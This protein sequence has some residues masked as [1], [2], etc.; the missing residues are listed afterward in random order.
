MRTLDINDIHGTFRFEYNRELFDALCSVPLCSY[1]RVDKS[2]RV[3]I[4][5]QNFPS[6]IKVVEK[7]DFS[8]TGDLSVVEKELSD[9]LK[10]R[11][12][13]QQEVVD[14][15]DYHKNLF[16]EW[17][18]GFGKTLASIK[19]IN[20]HKGRWLFVYKETTHLKNHLEDIEKHGMSHLL[21]F[22]DW[23]TYN[24][25]HKYSDNKYTGLILDEC[26][27]STSDLRQ[28]KLS[29]FKDCKIIATSATIDGTVKN[30]L[31]DIFGYFHTHKVTFDDAV[32][33]GILPKPR[34]YLVPLVLDNKRCLR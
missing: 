25:I 24:S 10:T 14:L 31:S 17:V 22:I 33:W 34:I 16:I 20:E 26:H 21:P 8:I 23:T 4:C 5:K 2:F 18:T 28:E 32:K 30:I 7:Y 12:E 29:K 11:D 13:L 15:S 9:K 19:I 1:Q 27:A 6:I 3:V